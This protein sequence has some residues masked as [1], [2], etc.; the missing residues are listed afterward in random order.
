MFSSSFFDFTLYLSDQLHSGNL[1]H[2]ISLT[3]FTY[4]I[5]PSVLFTPCWSILFAM[6]SL[7]KTAIPMPRCPCSCLCLCL[8]MPSGSLED[9]SQS[10]S[11]NSSSTTSLHRHLDSHHTQPQV[12]CK[13]CISAY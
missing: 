7:S 1:L 3:A 5:Y 13:F 2:V 11:N 4:A 9:E 10:K 6:P 8:F 12:L